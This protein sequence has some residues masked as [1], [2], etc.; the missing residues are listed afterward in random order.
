MGR[1]VACL[2]E[3]KT[4]SIVSRLPVTSLIFGDFWASLCADADVARKGE[5]LQLA[6]G[7]EKRVHNGTALLSSS[8]SYQ[9]RSHVGAFQRMKDVMLRSGNW[10]L[11]NKQKDVNA[12]KHVEILC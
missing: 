7:L 5:N 9:Y 11:C 3:L 6:V 8:A 4:S 2:A 10:M 12:S 1:L